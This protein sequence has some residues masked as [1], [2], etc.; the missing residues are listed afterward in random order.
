MNNRRHQRIEVQNVVANLSEEVDSLYGTVSNV[1]RVGLLLTDI[2]K[3]LNNQVEKLSVIVSAKGKDFKLLV[4]PKWMSGNNSGKKMGLAIIDAPL[5]WTVF[6][7]N[8]EPADEDIWAATAH[9]PGF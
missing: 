6:V 9:L 1:S 4:E 3:K 2:P 8:C 7:M 5:D